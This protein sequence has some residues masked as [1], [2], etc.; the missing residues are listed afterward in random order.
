MTEYAKLIVD[1][2]K[3]GLT[4]NQEEDMGILHNAS[5]KYKK[6]EES[7]DILREIA[8][9]MF[10]ILPDSEKSQLASRFEEMK[11]GVATDFAAVKNMINV[12]D[13]LKAKT[14]MESRLAAIEGSYE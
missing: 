9:M 1:S 2:I 4:G 8:T 7:T 13:F 5:E 6:D 11:S 10:E 12:G 14:T 3:N